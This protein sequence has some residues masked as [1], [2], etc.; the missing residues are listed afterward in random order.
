MRS[1]VIIL[2]CFLLVQGIEAAA[3]RGKVILRKKGSHP[4]KNPYINDNFRS[5][6]RFNTWHLRRRFQSTQLKN[7]DDPSETIVYLSKIP[8]RYKRKE[9][10]SQD[11][12]KIYVEGARFKPR[13]L[14]LLVGSTV[15]FTNID[16][17]VHDI[18][19]YS[20][21]KPFQTP[22]FKAKSAFVTFKKPGGVSLKS[23]VYRG[24]QGEIL[25]LDNPYFT[26]SR[27]DGYYSMRNLRP[28]IYH[29]TAWNP[30]FPSVTKEVEVN[31]GETITIDFNLSTMGLPEALV[32]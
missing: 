21:A 29:V 28:G 15:E 24:M 9:V 7:Y 8:E 30:E 27:S 32:R 18:Y 23:S 3:I 14:P 1:L 10:P 20:P 12:V 6:L 11:P 17:V 4:E 2:S 25:V 16:P 5:D 22:F 26:K 31:Y 19:S 13:T